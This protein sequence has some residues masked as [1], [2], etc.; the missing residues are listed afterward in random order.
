M[1]QGRGEG[2]SARDDLERSAAPALA[3]AALAGGVRP[4]PDP[5]GQPELRPMCEVGAVPHS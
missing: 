3:A 5:L 1:R 4:D 2:R